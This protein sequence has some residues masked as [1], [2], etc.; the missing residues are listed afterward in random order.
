M[1]QLP[2]RAAADT[3]SGIFGPLTTHPPAKLDDG[4][5]PDEIAVAATATT[6]TPAPLAPLDPSKPSAPSATPAPLTPTAPS[7]PPSALEA[8]TE[9]TALLELSAPSAAAAS[10][11]EHELSRKRSHHQFSTE[12]PVKRPRLSNGYENGQDTATATTATPMDID[13]I[14]HQPNP[15]NDNHAYPS[16][17]EG[18][19]ATSPVAHTEGPE[20]GTQMDKVEEL[21]PETTFIR[22]T[23]NTP[24]ISN[25][26]PS[27]RADGGINAPILLQ[28]EWNPKDPS[29][30]AAA[31]TD[32]LARVWKLPRATASESEVVDDHMF[33]NGVPLLDPEIPMTTTVT[34]LAWTS[35][36]STLA[37]ATDMGKKGAITIRSSDGILLET[38]PPPDPPIVKLCWNPGNTALLAISPVRCEGDKKAALITVYYATA[39]NSLTY[40]VPDY[41]I[42]SSPLDATWTNESEF[43]LSG[44]D[45]LVSLY[46]AETSIV[47]VRR[48]ETRTDDG[49]TQVIFDRRSKL[50]ATSSDKG[51][52]DLWDETGQRKSITAHQGAITTMA[53]QPL[54]PTQSNDDH[55]RLIATGGEDSAIMIWNARDPDSQSRCYFTMDSPIVRLAFTPDGAFIAGATSSQV[56]IWKVGSPA[57][58]RATWS[59]PPHPGW[60]SPRSSESDEE[61]EHCLSW[62]ASGQ[63]L[64][65]GSNSRVRFPPN[66][67][68]GKTGLD[69][70]CKQ[71]AVINFSR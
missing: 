58:P 43:I 32:S 8:P 63:K 46:C 41:D 6:I 30:L 36:G 71:L 15:Q 39:G 4:G 25:E 61:D 5:I 24:S 60:L 14:E 18:E 17:L 64:A 2:Q 59:R 22:L 47:Q 50:A 13:P 70:D 38:L 44:G 57:M 56:L 66:G 16:P 69:T 28:C 53:W 26:S 1:F 42:M 20:Q 52:L 55:E 65:Y 34:A 35:D 68:Y 11:D 29:V 19:E 21:L 48:F 31:G 9:P 33:S 49:F 7:A 51:I 45:M 3:E 62:D 67:L 54:P 37:V 40:L 10:T 27:P 12:A 23:D